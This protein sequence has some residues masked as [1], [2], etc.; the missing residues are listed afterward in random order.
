MSVSTQDSPQ[1][2]APRYLNF[3]FFHV[4]DNMMFSFI[5]TMASILMNIIN[6]FLFQR[7]N[8]KFNF[9]LMFLQQFVC[10][11][12]FIILINSS[13]K[14]RA[15]VGEISIRDFIQ[16]KL[17]YIGFCVLFICNYISSFIGNQMVN[18]AMYL[19]LRKFLT[20]MNYL[21]DRFINKK[22]LPDYFTQ[23][24]LCIFFGSIFTGINDFTSEKIG[25]IVVF[26]NNTFSVFQ[27]Q[28]SEQFSKKNNIPNIKLLV[29]NSFLATPLLLVIILISGE[30]GKIMDYNIIKNTETEGLV[31]Y[32]GFYFTLLISCTFA[33]V[34]NASFFISNERNSSLFTHLFSNSKVKLFKL[35]IRTYS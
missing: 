3:Y 22:K 7:Y 16:R 5:Y 32:I 10:L 11:I 4:T 23:S 31:H 19:I 34:I 30:I 18:T 9:T 27:A 12:F 17:Q 8:F 13:P 25:Y 29:Y 14:V 24:V 21:Y 26:I 35:N 20:I 1:Q 15:Q 6:R 2:K 28:A 33:L